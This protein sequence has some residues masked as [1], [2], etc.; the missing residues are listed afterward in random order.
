M[1]CSNDADEEGRNEGEG[2]C[3]PAGWVTQAHPFAAEQHTSFCFLTHGNIE[4][5]SPPSMGRC[6]WAIWTRPQVATERR[7]V[8][9]SRPC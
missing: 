9:R 5:G 8:L 4:T 7:R 3:D 6:A 2:G 1:T